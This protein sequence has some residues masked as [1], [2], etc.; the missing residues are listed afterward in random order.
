MLTLTSLTEVNAVDNNSHSLSFVAAR[1]GNEESLKCLL[2]RGANPNFT[3]ILETSIN[4]V[5]GFQKS[6]DP[7]Y[8]GHNIVQICKYVYF[9]GYNILQIAAQNGHQSVVKMLLDRHKNLAYV[10]NDMHLNAFNLAVENGHFEIM[11]MF[12]KMNSSLADIISLYQ[13]SKN[14]YQHIVQTLLSYG[15]IYQCVPCNG[16]FDWLLL[17]SNRKQQRAKINNIKLEYG[18][19]PIKTYFHD[20]WRL[21]TCETA[22]NAAVRKGHLHVVNILMKEEDNALR[23]TTY[24]GKTPLMTAVKYN[25][26]EIFKILHYKNSTMSLKCEHS[27]N[28]FDIYFQS[29]LDISE[30]AGL[31]TERC[32]SGA[33]VVHLLAM[34]GN[35]DMLSFMY[36]SGFSDWDL[37]DT[38]N[39]T[40]LHYAFCHNTNFFITAAHELKLNF[41]ARTLNMSTIFHSAAIC[42]GLS[43][44]Q[45]SRNDY[46]YKLNVTDVV[47]KDGRSILHYSMLMPLD[48][49]GRVRQGK[50]WRRWN[51]MVHFCRV[52]R[53]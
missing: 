12:L 33:S 14:G 8:S 43:L 25:Q 20:D 11:N 32:P 24:N 9:C 23:C 15:V 26:T 40:P 35:S 50:I 37:T 16:T 52:F 30:R 19:F 28:I 51:N 42:K 38:E 53:F 46:K 4:H 49:D 48:K 34:H 22:L 7:F 31:I 47:D 10:E 36:Q 13:A 21:I 2:D 39:A 27:F 6:H 5:Y 29:K 44:Y 3:V 1:K 45:N 18:T 41:T 17:L